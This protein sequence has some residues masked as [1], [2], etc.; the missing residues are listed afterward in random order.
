LVIANDDAV[1]VGVGGRR[2]YKRD[3]SS[4]GSM[5]WQRV[6][7]AA[8]G[9]GDQGMV[10]RRRI[11]EVVEMEKGGLE[12][13]VVGSCREQEVV[14]VGEV[15]PHVAAAVAPLAR[16]RVHGR[17]P[18]TSQGVQPPRHVSQPQ[19]HMHLLLAVAHLHLHQV[20]VLQPS[21]PA[22]AQIVHHRHLPPPRLLLLFTCRRQL[23][24]C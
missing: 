21:L 16:P 20:W 15:M 2:G 12:D 17:H 22:S 24:C 6:M 5:R 19:L 3:V 1:G 18:L 8:A 7:S 13:V 14:R 9:G 23:T 11:D 10:A 4:S